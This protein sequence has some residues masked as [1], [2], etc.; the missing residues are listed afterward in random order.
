MAVYHVQGNSFC[1]TAT[2]T[3]HDTSEA[4]DSHEY[5]RYIVTCQYATEPA[6]LAVKWEV[7]S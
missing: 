4:K 6:N 5:S 1:L 2:V 7:R 3:G